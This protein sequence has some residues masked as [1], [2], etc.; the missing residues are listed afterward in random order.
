MELG[1]DRQERQ[2]AG[3]RCLTHNRAVDMKSLP[4][5]LSAEAQM[6][7]V[8]ERHPRW[9]PSSRRFSATSDHVNVRR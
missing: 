5:R 9:E 3:V 6:R 1:T 7:E 8:Y 2:F 4:E